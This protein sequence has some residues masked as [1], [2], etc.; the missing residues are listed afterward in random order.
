MGCNRVMLDNCIE[1]HKTES[2]PAQATVSFQPGTLIEPHKAQEITCSD[3]HTEHMGTDKEAGL[4]NYGL[5]VRCHNGTFKIPKDGKV[6]P[7]GTILPPPHGGSLIGKLKLKPEYPIPGEVW[8]G[9]TVDRWKSVI[10]KWQIKTGPKNLSPYDY[11]ANDPFKQFHL[12][13]MAGDRDDYGLCVICHYKDDGSLDLNTESPHAACYKCHVASDTSQNGEQLANCNTCHPQHGRAGQFGRLTPE[14]G[15]EKEF[16]VAL[17]NIGNGIGSSVGRTGDI[18]TASAIRHN[19]D[20]LTF[21]SLH[22]SGAIPW[23]VWLGLTAILPIAG[24]AIIVANSARLKNYLGSIKI[25]AKPDEGA[26]AGSACESGSPSH[27][28]QGPAYPH[29]MIDIDMHWLSRLC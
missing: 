8:K 18:G 6:G 11:A 29:P 28:T 3:C 9:L 7:A 17:S 10:D 14:P 27:Q 21:R 1:C 5:C 22:K 16:L 2:S 26:K 23:Y 13:H 15:K 12:L 25:P 4:L 19:R 20:T 24:L